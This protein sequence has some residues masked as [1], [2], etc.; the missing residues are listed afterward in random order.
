MKEHKI[1]LENIGR[2]DRVVTGGGISGKVTKVDNDYEVTVEIAKDVKVKVQRSLISAVLSKTEPKG[3]VPAGDT[4]KQSGGNVLGKIFGFGGGNKQENRQ[5]DQGSVPVTG[6]VEASNAD[7]V[8]SDKSVP[9]D[10]PEKNSEKVTSD[11]E[12]TSKN[13]STKK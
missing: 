10:A 3:D 4:P 5:S 11:I 9:T 7:V 12:S 13:S 1:M 6:E 8:Q 2:G